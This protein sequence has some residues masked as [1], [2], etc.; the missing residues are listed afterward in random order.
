MKST[1]NRTKF[2][3]QS[4][5]NIK[6]LKGKR[7]LLRLDLN[8]PLNGSKISDDSRLKYA[9]PTISYLKSK[10]AKVIILSH[11]GSDGKMSLKEVARNLGKKIPL[12]FSSEILGKKFLGRISQMKN[13]SVLMLENIRREKGEM[14]NSKTFSV[15]LSSLADIYVND[16]FSASHRNHASIVSLPKLLPSFI[17]FQFEKEINELSKAFS[18]K[19]PFLFIL[20]GAKFSTKLPLIK[21]YLKIADYVFVGGA[22]MNS[23]FKSQG[24]EIGKSLS[25]SCGE[26]LFVMTRNEKLVLPTDI[27]VND[28]TRRLTNAIGKNEI[29]RDIGP[30]SLGKIKN[31]ISKSKEIIFNGPLGEYELGF[32]GTTKE[33][34]KTIANS[35]AHTIV[36]GGDTLSLI[37]KLKIEN[38]F[39]F[40]SSAGGAMIEF[41]SNGTL[42]GIEALKKS[43]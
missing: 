11:L 16:A 4:I 17:G 26:N 33:V 43:K 18:P 22:I 35:N 24:L 41:L 42:V 14:S 19:R 29:I 38:K 2:K 34:L 27:I 20:G 10:G 5:K 13:G 23:F 32:D 15:E 21:K 40:V 9:I 7:V 1:S 31:L 8:V 28:G 37:S 30:S 3:L 39:S 6:N 36:G 12:G 25:D